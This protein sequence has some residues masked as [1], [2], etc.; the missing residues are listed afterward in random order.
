[1]LIFVSKTTLQRM[2]TLKGKAHF[3][4]N[5][6]LWM[7]AVKSIVAQDAELYAKI[8]AAAECDAVRR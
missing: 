8:T 3:K 6:V 2:K 1:M 4:L 7:S 5:N